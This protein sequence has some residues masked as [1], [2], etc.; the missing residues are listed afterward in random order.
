[1]HYWVITLA[2]SI[3]LAAGSAAADPETASGHEA[4]SQTQLQRLLRTKIETVTELAHNP[5][6]V[7]AVRAQNAQPQSP[8]QIAARD[9]EW[10]QT[11]EV[12]PFKKSLQE[13]EVGR[14]FHNLIDF[15]DSIYNEAFLTDASG[16]NVA[17]YPITSDYWQGDE[18]KWTAAFNDGKGATFVSPVAFDESTQ[19]PAIQISVPVMDEGEAIGVLVVGVKLTYVQARYLMLQ[20][21]TAP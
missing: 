10:R 7:R 13:N 15:N 17:A 2:T 18:K 6:I 11:N 9:E 4:F 8:A 16:A 3:G 1:M 21:H 5:T 19:T 20:G 14:Y 12:T